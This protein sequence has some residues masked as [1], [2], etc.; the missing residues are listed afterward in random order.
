MSLKGAVG[1]NNCHIMCEL[2]V[3]ISQIYGI[4][5]VCVV[6]LDIDVDLVMSISVDVD[7]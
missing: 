3:Y 2:G 5:L 6:Y 4:G 1:A 7:V